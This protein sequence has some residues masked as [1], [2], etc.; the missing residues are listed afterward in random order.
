VPRGRGGVSAW[1][2]LFDTSAQRHKA[3]SELRNRS[4]VAHTAAVNRR[5]LAS[6]HHTHSNCLCTQQTARYGPDDEVSST[7][8]GHGHLSLPDVTRAIL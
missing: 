5:C 7:E 1:Y 4:E 3:E 6:A 8:S 2:A